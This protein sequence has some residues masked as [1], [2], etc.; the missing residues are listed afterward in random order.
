MVATA[1]GWEAGVKVE[2]LVEAGLVE[3]EAVRAAAVA[4]GRRRRRRRRRWARET[5]EARV[6]ARVG[7]AAAAAVAAAVEEAVETGTAEVAVMATAAVRAASMVAAAMATVVAVRHLRRC[8]TAGSSSVA[9][10]TEAV[11]GWDCTTTARAVIEAPT[12]AE[13]ATVIGCLHSRMATEATASTTTSLEATEGPFLVGCGHTMAAVVMPGDSTSRGSLA[14]PRAGRASMRAADTVYMAAMSASTRAAKA[15]VET[16][17]GNVVT[18]AMHNTALEGTAER[19]AMKSNADKVV[20]EVTTHLRGTS[21]AERMVMQS[22]WAEA[23]ENK[24]WTSKKDTA[25]RRAMLLA[26]VVEVAMASEESTMGT[27]GRTST[28]AVVRERW[29]T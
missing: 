16:S 2:G 18:A 21:T 9:A 19:T 22:V 27:A 29:R 23:A 6:E 5:Q 4:M 24:C 1:G 11:V 8:R 12:T 25:G 17:L 26:T 7:R 15:Y 10:V 20:A 13:R 3:A 28:E 14:M